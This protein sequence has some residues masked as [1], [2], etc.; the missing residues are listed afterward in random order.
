M[1]AGRLDTK[2]IIESRST[3][4]NGVGDAIDTWSTHLTVWSEILTNSGKE[5]LQAREQHSSL[6]KVI[7][8][9]WVSG[10]TPK[11]RVNLGGEYYNILAAFDPWN[12]RR[13]LR[14]LCDAQL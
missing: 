2:I 10:I 13:E 6:A 5:F 9:R 11:M 4:P 8:I 7:T 3:A 14:L 1:R 12:T